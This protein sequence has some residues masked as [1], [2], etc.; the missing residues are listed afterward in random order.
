MS[1][2]KEEESGVAFL[3]QRFH[4]EEGFGQGIGVLNTNDTCSIGS[5]RGVYR[6]LWGLLY[7]LASRL[8]AGTLYNIH[9]EGAT[10]SALMSASSSVW[11]LEY[12][13]C[14]QN[15]G[16]VKTSVLVAEGPHT[17]GCGHFSTS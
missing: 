5:V 17:T 13:R 12:W 1:E 6:L 15:G 8:S 3:G 4:C 7:Q 10:Q 14:L 11:V 2:S 9:H 16:L